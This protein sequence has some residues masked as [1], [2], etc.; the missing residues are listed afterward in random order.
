MANSLTPSMATAPIP[1]SGESSIVTPGLRRSC[2][3][4]LKLSDSSRR[5]S[6]SSEDP[7]IETLFVHHSAKVVSFS[8]PS[9]VL[10]RPTTP[11]YGAADPED[12][13]GTLPW[14][15]TVERTM[16]AG[17]L[18]LYRVPGSVAFLTSGKIL[19][20]ILAKSQCW[21]VDGETIFVLRIRTG[22]YYRIELPNHSIEDR[23][24]A[25]ELKAVLP[26]IL[27]YEQTPCPFA[28][29]F[30]VTLPERLPVRKRPW[31]PREKPKPPPQQSETGKEPRARPLSGPSLDETGGAEERLTQ[32]L[33]SDSTEGSIDYPNY[34]TTASPT[35]AF[36]ES[37]RPRML[38]TE[39]SITAPPILHV[40]PPSLQKAPYQPGRRSSTESESSSVSSSVESFH[41]FHSSLSLRPPSPPFSATTWSTVPS[42]DVPTTVDL[43]QFKPEGLG[44]PDSSNG[45][46]AQLPAV[47]TSN[48]RTSPKST[49]PFGQE[50]QASEEAD[51]PYYN[52]SDSG[53]GSGSEFWPDSAFP[54][55]VDDQREL[56]PRRRKVPSSHPRRSLS[57]L[58]LAA[59]LF[60]PSGQG[61]GYHLPTDVI[62]KTCSLLFGPPVH[63]IALM[64]NVASKIANG[65]VKGVVV[66]HGERGERIPCQWDYSD[67]DDGPATQEDWRP[68]EETDEEDDY[69]IPLSN[70]GSSTNL[71]AAR[72]AS[73]ASDHGSIAPGVSSS[74]ASSLASFPLAPE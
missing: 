69:G 46:M 5:A 51:E 15:S 40:Q 70:G 36:E 34:R 54:L 72:R 55:P 64:L 6:K 73:Q 10:R 32:D 38:N 50:A 74:S 17:P 3:L 21:C 67:S 8:P 1:A 49:S 12:Q 68:E 25:A 45:P 28:R 33:D 18:R 41:S 31:R 53:A 24:K 48:T 52:S 30:T 44:S 4:P 61:S 26:K 58:P 60:T 62:Q 27:Q 7:V 22:T 14:N 42:E 29:E 9:H 66:T 19:H 20:P 63:L 65:A 39:R 35:Q 57:P 37:S 16:A 11:D 59:N 23:E 2:T 13:V 56:R 47:Q 71:A 43:P